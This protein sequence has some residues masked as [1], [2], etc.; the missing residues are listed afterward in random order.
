[1][2]RQFKAIP[3]RGIV[4]S[5]ITCGTVD[6]STSRAMAEEYV[7]L[8]LEEAE[9]SEPNEIRSAEDAADAGL[10][11]VESSYKEAKLTGDLKY[12]YSTWGIPRMSISQLRKQLR[13]AFIEFASTLDID[14]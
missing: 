10:D 14:N 3:G 2:K 12:F 5:T 4:A 11:M 1:M 9:F 6:D 7:T 13:P 8:A